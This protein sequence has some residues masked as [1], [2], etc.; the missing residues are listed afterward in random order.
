MNHRGVLDIPISHASIE[1][2]CG[3]LLMALDNTAYFTT[4]FEEFPEE[5]QW[6]RTKGTMPPGGDTV[7]ADGSVDN[8][9]SVLVDGESS[10][11]EETT[12]NSIAHP[13]VLLSIFLGNWI[14]HLANR[15]RNCGDAEAVVQLEQLLCS[16]TCTVCGRSDSTTDNHQRNG[17][18]TGFVA[19]ATFKS[20]SA[21]KWV[22]RVFSFEIIQDS[23]LLDGRPICSIGERAFISIT[24]FIKVCHSHK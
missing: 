16:I 9:A 14:I 24:N 6:K 4:A 20:L 21:V 15:Y 8:I 11:R 3:D 10:D 18:G 22:L 13:G 2:V 19:K 17:C 5:V 12:I 23:L 1:W 7:N